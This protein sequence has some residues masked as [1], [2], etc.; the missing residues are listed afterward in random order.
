MCLG[1]GGGGEEEGVYSSVHVF[2]GAI[3][4]YY[5]SLLHFGRVHGEIPGRTAQF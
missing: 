4:R 2:F 1:G 5:L 3:C